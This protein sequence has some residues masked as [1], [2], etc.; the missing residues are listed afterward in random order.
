LAHDSTYP[1]SQRSRHA[2]VSMQQHSGQA[3]YHQL[4]TWSIS[5]WR[6][7]GLFQILIWTPT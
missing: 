2:V 5:W 7:H 1:A 4:G 3:A 6:R